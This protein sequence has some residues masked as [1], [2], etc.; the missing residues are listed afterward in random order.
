MAAPYTLMGWCLPSPQQ[1][2]ARGSSVRIQGHGCISLEASSVRAQRLSGATLEAVKG[3]GFAALASPPEVTLGAVPRNIHPLHALRE[4]V[5]AQPGLRAFEGYAE[6]EQARVRAASTDVSPSEARRPAQSSKPALRAITPAPVQ[7]LSAAPAAAAPSANRHPAP[8]PAAEAAVKVAAAAAPASHAPAAAERLFRRE[9]LQAQQGSGEAGQNL[10]KPTGS[11]WGILAVVASLVVVVFV[12]A[13]FA[14]IEVTVKAPGALRAP[15]GLRAVESALAGSVVEVKVRAGDEVTEGQLIVKLAV[16]QLDASLTSKRQELEALKHQNA[17]GEQT[18]QAYSKRIET[19][20]RHRRN[21]L[22]SRRQLN[23]ELR[24]QRRD[25]LDRTRELV[26]EGAGSLNQELVTRESLH[27]A[28]DAGQMLSSSLADIDVQ[29]AEVHNQVAE[30]ALAREIEWARAQTAVLELETLS[31]RAQVR[32]PAAG[33]VESLL[34]KSG[35]VVQPGQLL[36]QI[37]PQGAPRSIVAFLPARETAFVA[38]GTSA[39]VELESLPVSEFGM[40]RATVKRISADIADPQELAATFGQASPAPSVRVELEVD[41]ASEK[42][43]PHLR[44]GERVIVRLHRRER[45]IISLMFDFARTMLE[46]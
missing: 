2:P 26:R 20:L 8:A 19:A 27:E 12:G 9:A 6:P 16:A 41:S 22:Q 5:S 43:A 23:H 25:L 45:R 21:V 39:R 7:R 11:N 18:D 36:A 38:V 1:N 13:L 35:D 33:R 10:P 3:G 17:L 31:A 42:M 44:S 32:S 14:S 46:Q 24:A 30:R 37:V 29:L 15:D 28:M 40:A 4:P 34:A